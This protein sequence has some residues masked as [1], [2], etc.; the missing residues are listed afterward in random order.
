MQKQEI[1]DY[2]FF[3]QSSQYLTQIVIILQVFIKKVVLTKKEENLCRFLDN[4]KIKYHLQKKSLE[5]LLSQVYM[6]IVTEEKNLYDKMS[7]TL[8][9]VV[10]Q[11]QQENI[12]AS[13]QIKKM[14][15]IN[16]TDKF[17]AF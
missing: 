3:L 15:Q 4:E 13:Q 8:I 14:Q 16:Q 17:T 9:S 10:Y 2:M 5:F 1:A 6:I 7:E 12:F 11:V